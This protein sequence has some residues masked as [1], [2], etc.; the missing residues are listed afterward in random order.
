MSTC[1]EL[2][3]NRRQFAVH[4]IAGLVS[5]IGLGMSVPAAVY[6]FGA[7]SKRETGW[8]DAGAVDSLR[9]GV[10]VEL[11]IFRVHRDGWKITSEQDTVWVLKKGD[12]LIAFSPRCTHLGCA[13]HWDLSQKKFVCPCH[14]SVFSETGEVVAGP[15]P[16]PLDRYL[17]RVDGDRLWLGKLQ[18][19]DEN[20]RAISEGSENPRS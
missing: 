2:N 16:R 20:T 8:I 6:V 17:T 13:Y 5:A 14:G 10:P 19:S 12:E 9:S 7:P 3:I 1:E 18:S 4:A 15:A 11:P